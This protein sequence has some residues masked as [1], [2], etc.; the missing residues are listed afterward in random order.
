M[1]WSLAACRNTLCACAHWEIKKRVITCDFSKPQ[2]RNPKEFRLFLRNVFDGPF[3]LFLESFFF[4]SFFFALQRVNHGKSYRKRLNRILGPQ[5]GTIVEE[6]HSTIQAKN[7]RCFITPQVYIQ[8][9]NSN[10]FFL[11]F[12]KTEKKRNFKKVNE[13]I[14]VP[15]SRI[16]SSLFLKY[17]SKKKKFL[18]S[19]C[20]TTRKMGRKKIKVKRISENSVVT[21]LKFLSIFCP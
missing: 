9:I 13:Y 6:K 14:R 20:F 10:T 2:K 7:D 5:T 18:K 3:S 1:G 21:R 4:F 12:K 17:Y 16:Y 19:V 8:S 15:L 11:F